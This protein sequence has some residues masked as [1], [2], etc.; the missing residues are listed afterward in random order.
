MTA[1]KVKR[2]PERARGTLFTFIARRRFAR[3]P[4]AEV[5][6]GVGAWGSWR[7]LVRGLASLADTDWPVRSSSNPA[8]YH[9]DGVWT[10]LAASVVAAAG[11]LVACVALPTR[12]DEG[13]EERDE[14][15]DADVDTEER[16]VYVGKQSDQ[17]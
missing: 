15:D 14:W 12:E 6:S 7:S 10:M 16:A 9:G 17:G 3:E 8:D 13:K 2:V 4:Y 11:C 1:S 5:A